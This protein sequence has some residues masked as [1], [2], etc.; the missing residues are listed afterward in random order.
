MSINLSRKGGTC[1]LGEYCLVKGYWNLV[2][3]VIFSRLDVSLLVK[4]TM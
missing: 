2:K 4:S 1:W 3:G